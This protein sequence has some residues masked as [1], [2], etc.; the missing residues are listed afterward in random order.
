MPEAALAD[1]IVEQAVAWYVRLASGLQTAPDEAAFA[2][3]RQAHPDHELAWQRL[4]SMNAAVSRGTAHVAPLIARS[5]LARANTLSH[6]RRAIK[7]LLLAGAGGLGWYGIQEQAMLGTRLESL[8]ADLRTSAGELRDLTLADGTRLQLN[9]ATAVNVQYSGG[10]RRIVL[11][12][13]EIMVTTAPDAA[14][15]P[16]I[17]ATREGTLRPVGTRYAVWRGA[18]AGGGYD[19]TGL[20]VHEGLVEVRSDDAASGGAL[21]VR[22]GEQTRFSRLRI[23]P[24]TPL[25][26]TRQSWAG[27]TL[28]AA[29]MRLRDFVADLSRYRPGRLRCAPEVENLLITGAWPLDGPD[30]TD[31]ILESLERRLPLRVHRHTRYWVTIAAR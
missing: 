7:A 13:G 5:T 15:R 3:W 28:T 4:R 1:E 30:P 31:R 23:D 22:A 11:L 8:T 10:E 14:G 6:R 2:R 24:A 12:Q 16:F 27:G 17:V 29:G 20:A 9:T 21:L 26:E 18:S 25:D 19:L